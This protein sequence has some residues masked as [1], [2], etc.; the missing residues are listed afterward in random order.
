[1]SE[2]SIKTNDNV[3]VAKFG[4]SSVADAS[5][6]R[7]LQGIVAADPRRKL[8][9]VSAPGKRTPQDKKITDL[10]YLCHSLSEQWIDPSAPF[11]VIRERY[12]GIARDLGVDGDRIARDIV[13]GQIAAMQFDRHVEPWLMAL[14]AGS[15]TAPARQAKEQC[16]LRR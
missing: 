13:R 14:S 6:I 4:G 11:I 5:Q 8:I 2:H 7:K 15:T 1:M 12:L 3:I 10:L 9:V 16:R